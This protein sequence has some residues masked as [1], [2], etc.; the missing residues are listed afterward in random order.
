MVEAKIFLGT[1]YKALLLTLL[2]AG[3]RDTEAVPLND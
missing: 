3:K 2:L 1:D